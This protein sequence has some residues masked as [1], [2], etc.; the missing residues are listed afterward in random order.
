MSWSVTLTTE[1]DGHQIIVADGCDYTH[2]T[3]RMI[4]DAGFLG[5]PYEVHSWTAKKLG[6][7]LDEAIKN[8][9]R[10]PKRYRAMNPA[11]GWGD[12]DSLVG[13]LRELR[14]Q[15]RTFPSAKVSMSA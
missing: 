5:W 6:E 14:D 9:E 2:N 10:D 8:L 3:N 11:N 15:C 13:V 1:L 7:G 4:R 12:Y